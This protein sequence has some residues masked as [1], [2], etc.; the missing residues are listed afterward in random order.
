MYIENAHS[1]EKVKEFA[2]LF[3]IPIKIIEKHWT[4]KRCESCGHIVD[5]A[6]PGNIVEGTETT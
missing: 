2:E 6:A 4:S 3:G 5:W 1:F